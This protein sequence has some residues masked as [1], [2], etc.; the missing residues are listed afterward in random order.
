[1]VQSRNQTCSNSHFGEFAAFGVHPLGCQTPPNTLKR[2]HQ[3]RM[4]ENCCQTCKSI[5]HF[6]LCASRVEYFRGRG[7]ERTQASA[8][9]NHSPGLFEALAKSLTLRLQPEF[10]S[11]KIC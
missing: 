5:G 10:Q 4:D 9:R 1:P 11:H 2:G 6:H 7:G 3:T 8:S